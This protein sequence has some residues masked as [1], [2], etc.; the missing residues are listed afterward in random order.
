MRKAV[1]S[2]IGGTFLL[3]AAVLS[4]SRSDSTSPVQPAQVVNVSVLPASTTP[5]EPDGYRRS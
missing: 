5:P 1:W 3:V 2:G 4:C